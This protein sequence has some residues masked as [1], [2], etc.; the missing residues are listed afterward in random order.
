MRFIKA[1]ETTAAKKRIY[2]DLRDATDGI[3]PETGEAGGQPQ[4]STDGA[5]WT[6]T[7]IGTLTHIGNGRYYADLTDA[8][9]D[10]AGRRIETRFKSANTAESMG[11]SVEVVAIDFFDAIT[12]G[13]KILD[14]D[15]YIDDS[16][17]TQ[18]KLKIIEKSSI[19]SPVVYATKNLKKL[20]GTAITSLLS[21]VAR[22]LT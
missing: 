10:T 7:G 4:I 8:A 1:G 15:W 22:Q 9:V 21:P 5:A 14:A 17:E 3:T 2:F 13:I 12:M 6:N 20:D 11:D 16:D 19:G 18:L